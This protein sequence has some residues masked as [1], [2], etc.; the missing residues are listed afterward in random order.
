MKVYIMRSPDDVISE[1][2]VQSI[3]NATPVA[4]ALLD[5][6]VGDAVFLDGDAPEARPLRI[7]KI[8]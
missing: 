5:A 4:K 3:G 6:E 1:D 2:G 7:L 8:W